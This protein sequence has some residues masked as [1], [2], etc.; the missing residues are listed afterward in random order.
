MLKKFLKVL[1]FIFAWGF[2]MSGVGS[3]IIVFLGG[4]INLPSCYL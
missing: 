1:L 2:I 4:S 3:L